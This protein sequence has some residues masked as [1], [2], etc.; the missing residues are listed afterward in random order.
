MPV[1]LEA[2]PG[3]HTSQEGIPSGQESTSSSL[4]PC[5]PEA[6]GVTKGYPVN[7]SD[8]SGQIAQ[9]PVPLAQRSRFRARPRLRIRTERPVRSGSTVHQLAA[10]VQ[11]SNAQ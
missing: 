6:F 11:E 5:T 4:E 9:R 10:R 3:R 2:D 8:E 7:G 1:Q